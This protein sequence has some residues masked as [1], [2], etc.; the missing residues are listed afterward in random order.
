M[1]TLK[2]HSTQVEKFTNEKFEHHLQVECDRILHKVAI[3][4]AREN[5]EMNLPKPETSVGIPFTRD[6]WAEFQKLVDF[7]KDNNPAES[8]F[9]KKQELEK[10]F[11]EKE[12]EL[13]KSILE[14]DEQIRTKKGEIARK[15]QAIIEKDEKWDRLRWFLYLIMLADILLASTVF[16]LMGMNWWGSILIG[17]GLALSVLF[18]SEKAP[19]LIRKGKTKLQRVGIICLL[20]LVVI[21][22][23]Y[24]LAKFRIIQ[25]SD[26]LD[27]FKEGLSPIIFVALNYF[28]FAVV[29]IVSYFNKPTEEEQKI[30]NEINRKQKE[31]IK[32]EEE[33]KRLYQEKEENTASNFSQKL[34]SAQVVVYARTS[35]LR[36]ISSYEAVYGKYIST[37]LN[38]RKDRLIP[39]FFNDPPPPLRT[40]FQ[41]GDTYLKE[42]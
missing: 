14:N 6:I 22:V 23:F 2:L 13:S 19:D 33:G 7:S 37:N 20:S 28:V 34:T 42:Q 15:D 29:T 26:N 32:L 35:E 16:E 40:Y 1:K 30:L 39:V 41:P 21:T 36:I 31:L 11:L 25:L 9:Y 8:E 38:Y 24:C 10:L 18:F 27:V 5:A 3:P 17:F 12:N 4:L